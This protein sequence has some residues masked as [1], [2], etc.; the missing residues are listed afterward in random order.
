MALIG[1]G[2]DYTDRDFDALNERLKSLGRSA[3]PNWTDEAKAN[4][5][6][7]LREFN[8][9]AGDRLGFMQD[10]QAGESRITTCQQRKNMLALCKAINYVP[11][12]PQ[13]AQAVVTF[14]LSEPVPTGRTVTFSPPY[15]TP[16]TNAV[17]CSTEDTDQ[18]QSFELTAEVVIAAGASTGTGTVENS[19]KHGE[20]FVSTGL[21]DQEYIL[22]STPFLD[23]S[24]VVSDE[25]G[26]FE[27]ADNFLNSTDTDRHFTVFV[28][29]N[30]KAKLKFA[31]G[32]SG[33]IPVGT[34]S[35]VYKSGGG[36]AGRVPANTIKK[37][38]GSFVDSTGAS[39]TVTVNN[40]AAASGGDDRQSLAS[41]RELA[42]LSVRTNSRCI[43]RDDFEINALRASG[44]S[45]SLML[46][47]NEDP[48]VT[49]ANAGGLYVVSPSAVVG[50]LS[51]PTFP[52]DAQCAAIL[53]Y[54]ATNH[55]WDLTFDPT[56]LPAIFVDIGVRARI[57]LTKAA[58]ANAAA[59][60]AVV[61]AIVLKIQE[62]FA[63][64]N[65]DGT[66][67]TNVDFGLKLKETSAT[68]T[69]E[70]EVSRLE[71]LVQNV[72]GVREVDETSTGFQLIAYRVRS[73]TDGYTSGTYP[74]EQVQALTRA[75]VQLGMKDFPRMAGYTWGSNTPYIVL[76]DGD[77]SDAQLCPAVP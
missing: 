31:N 43:T 73:Y 6:N 51:R 25:M 77:N 54:L 2:A 50:Y 52:T 35:M 60:T 20:S 63:L 33:A 8:A 64:L 66:T 48:T 57:F 28:D 76:L 70:I 59:T 34:V 49:P 53:Q 11:W 16:G 38:E 32:I 69:A 71:A 61:N 1:Q 18:P 65:A 42:P 47:R 68:E 12:G 74:A 3:F 29:E 4:F 67:N 14:T 46:T 39:V 21:P 36:L 15:P 5:A 44:V 13:A 45:R 30:D 19:V 58:K 55:P 40:A 9:F 10:N 75:D 41:I 22:E 56:A 27:K 26:T 37:L 62:F 24:A 17:T 72:A 7:L 23:G